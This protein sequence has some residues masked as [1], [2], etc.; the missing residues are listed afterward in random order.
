MEHSETKKMMI[1]ASKKM[2]AFE[3]LTAGISE[4]IKNKDEIKTALSLGLNPEN[5][6]FLETILC[7]KQ[8]IDQKLDVIHKELE[9]Q[10][11]ILTEQYAKEKYSLEIGDIVDC[12]RGKHKWALCIYWI[13]LCDD[14]SLYVS[15]LKV[16][17]QG[18]VGKRSCG[19]YTD[20]EYWTKR[21][22]TDL[23][24]KKFKSF[25]GDEYLISEKKFDIETKEYNDALNTG[26][27]KTMLKFEE[28]H[29]GW[30]LISG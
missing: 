23:K 11:D 22:G 27:E 26:D 17:K 3:R 13:N 5:T 20:S 10:Q 15:G 7:E 14:E 18:K 25:S 6:Q 1:E 21:E 19:F 24:M 30:I 4:Y 12:D 16:T 28:G 9:S 29:T 2:E 8:D